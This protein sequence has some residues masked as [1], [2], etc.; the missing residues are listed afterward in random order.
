MPSKLVNEILDLHLLEY[1]EEIR[2]RIN[3]KCILKLRDKEIVLNT[4]ISQEDFL[5]ILNNMCNNSIYSYQNQICEG[6]INLIGGHRVGIV[7]TSSI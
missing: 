5:C 4:Q 3:K 6:Y 1:L 2:L 7:R